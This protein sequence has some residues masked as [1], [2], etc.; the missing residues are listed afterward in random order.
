MKRKRFAKRVEK[1][2][3]LLQHIAP[4]TTLKACARGLT[5]HIEK[6]KNIYKRERLRVIREE[7]KLITRTI[8]F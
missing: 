5:K 4:E 7:I 1:D 2:E 3:N 6:E 8:Y